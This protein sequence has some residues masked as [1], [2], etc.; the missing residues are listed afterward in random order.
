MD[1]PA[2]REAAISR[3]A[4]QLARELWDWMGTRG[5]SS[6][7]VIIAMARCLGQMSVAVSAPGSSRQVLRVLCEHAEMAR[8][9]KVASDSLEA[10][11]LGALNPGRG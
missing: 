1:T 4:D 11:G 7:A 5:A 10:A 2:D 9:V 8:G 6:G 3:E